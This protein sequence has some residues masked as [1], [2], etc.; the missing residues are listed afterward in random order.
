MK[1]IRQEC[2]FPLRKCKF[3]KYKIKPAV[4]KIAFYKLPSNDNNI[5]AAKHTYE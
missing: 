1:Y 3:Q 5:Y 2:I 4:E